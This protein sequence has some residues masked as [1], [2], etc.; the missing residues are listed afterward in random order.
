MTALE[1]RTK[2]VSEKYFTPADLLWRGFVVRICCAD[3][4]CQRNLERGCWRI[5]CADLLCQRNL[6]RNL[7]R[8]GK[9]LGIAAVIPIS[10]VRDGVAGGHEPE[11]GGEWGSVR[12]LHGNGMPRNCVSGKAQARPVALAGQRE[13]AKGS[14]HAQAGALN[15]KAGGKAQRGNRFARARDR[16][17]RS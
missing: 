12:L 4:L 14:D 8:P 9:G 16:S 11:G 7:E 2:S 17:R 3:L 1:P 13:L 6:E 5:C 15:G 10:V